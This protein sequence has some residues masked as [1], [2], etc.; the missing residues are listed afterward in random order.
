MTSI[1]SIS[2]GAIL[3][4]NFIMS[5][6]LHPCPVPWLLPVLR[7]IQEDRHSSRHG[8]GGNLRYGSCVRRYLAD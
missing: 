2:L 7:R 5:Q 6:Q 8:H 3:I 4:N 1:L